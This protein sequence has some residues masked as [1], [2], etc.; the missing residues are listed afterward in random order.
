MTNTVFHWMVTK[1]V[2]AHVWCRAASAL[3]GSIDNRDKRSSLL[4][5]EFPIIIFGPSEGRSEPT[6]ALATYHTGA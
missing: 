2:N 5:A 6:L 1:P 3:R 4:Q